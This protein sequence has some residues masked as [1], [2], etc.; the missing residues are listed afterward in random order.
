MT[1]GPAIR[2]KTYIEAPADR[3]YRT[4]TTAEGWDAWFTRGT[5]L[6]ARLGGQLLLRWLDPGPT[7]HRVTLWG[8]VHE[9]ME[10][11]GAIVALDP[12]RRFAFEWSAAGHPTTVSFSLEERGSG[13]LLSVS[14]EGYLA[15][16]LGTLAAEGPMAEAP[17]FAMCASGWGE[18]MTLLK[19]Y[20]E[21]GL[22]YGPVPAPIR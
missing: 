17:P 7:R 21:H 13:T 9:C 11:G 16:E 12:G 3:V 2:W 19:F 6:D 20:L 18:A 1:G 8:P 22:V 10:A 14:E 5:T 15:E 4:L